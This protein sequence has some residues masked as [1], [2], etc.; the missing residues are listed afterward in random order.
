MCGVEGCGM[1]QCTPVHLHLADLSLAAYA[2]D[3]DFPASVSLL[4]FIPIFICYCMLHGCWENVLLIC[5]DG[6]GISSH[7]I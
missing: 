2:C 3:P 7:E 5:L 6:A 1:L 4:K